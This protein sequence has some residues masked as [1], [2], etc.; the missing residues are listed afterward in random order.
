M[1][2]IKRENFIKSGIITILLG[3]IYYPA[4]VWMWG[5]WNTADTYYSHGPLII[6]ASLFFL[7]NMKEEL[8]KLKLVP[9]NKGI[10][11]MVMA[12]ISHIAGTLIKFYFFSAVSFVIMLF[13]IILYFFG[14][15]ILRKTQFP[16]LYLGFMIPAP[17]VL[18]S[19]I[20][21]RMKL[22]AGSM[23]AVLLNNIGLEAVRDGS[24]IKMSRSY[25]EIEAP[26]SGLRSLI[27]LLAFGAAFAYMTKHNLLKKWILFLTAFP[28]AIFANVMRIVLL[29][30][31]G[32][33]YGMKAAQGWVH[34]F[35]GY[36]LFAV[37]AVGMIAVNSLLVSG[38]EESSK[39][40]VASSEKNPKSE[41]GSLR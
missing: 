6:I 23:A 17:L 15:E 21:I 32:E 29:G 5:R 12:L 37:A 8:A 31:V 9:S 11:L 19:N 13:G 27:A 2:T 38:K 3:I 7:W 40:R 20:V 18:I 35:S 22:F 14:G 26:C 25:L 34:D 30:W 24:I 36:L 1:I 4:F 33:V 39:E 16:L 10:I 28:I 41:G